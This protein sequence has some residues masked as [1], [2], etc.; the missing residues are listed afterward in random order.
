MTDIYFTERDEGIIKKALHG[1]HYK[2]DVPHMLPKILQQNQINVLPI[3]A[4]MLVNDWNMYCV[5]CGLL[6]D[7][8]NEKPPSIYCEERGCLAQNDDFDDVEPMAVIKHTDYL[9]IDRGDHFNVDMIH[10]GPA[11]NH[12]T[13]QINARF[14]IQGKDRDKFFNQLKNLIGDFSI[15]VA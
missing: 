10:H 15:Q 14:S 5:E 1:K 4:E 11:D 12:I 6:N 7:P 9:S 3:R 13:V 2:R 8:S